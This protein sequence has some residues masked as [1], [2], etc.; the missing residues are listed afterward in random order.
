MSDIKTTV[1]ERGNRYG[2]FEDNAKLTQLLMD[3][4]MARSPHLLSPTHREAIHMIFHKISRMVV[5][6]PY[7]ADNPHDIAGYA[8]CLEEHIND[9]NAREAE[10]D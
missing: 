5:G 10:N 1:Q 2:S 4:V 6:D 9:V 7:Y 8:T 3:T